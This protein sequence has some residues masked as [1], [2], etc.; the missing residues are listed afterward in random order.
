MVSLDGVVIIPYP[1][2]TLSENCLSDIADVYYF[3]TR[4]IQGKT[5]FYFIIVG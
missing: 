1:A 5:L 3:V 4:I 2:F